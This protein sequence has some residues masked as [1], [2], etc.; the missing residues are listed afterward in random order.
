VLEIFA[1]EP[2]RADQ[3]RRSGHAVLAG[4]AAPRPTG[5]RAY[6]SLAVT[7]FRGNASTETVRPAR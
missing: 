3:G 7:R 6:A 2:S 5:A 1:L 4:T